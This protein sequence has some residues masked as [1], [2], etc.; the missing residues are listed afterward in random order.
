VE[1]HQRSFGGFQRDLSDLVILLLECGLK[2]VVMESFWL[3]WKSVSAALEQAG[4]PAHVVNARHARKVPGRKTDVSDSEWLA[5]LGRFG[6]VTPSFVPP[7]DLRELRL[8][9]RYRQKLA[10]T[11]AGEKNRLHKLLDDAGIKLGAVVA[12][13]GGV[14]AQAMI[15]GLLA[16]TP[17]E[18]LPDLAKGAMRKKR[19]LLESALDG[20]LSPRHRFVLRHIQSHIHAL[21]TEL[22]ELD[23]YLIDAMAPYAEYW[24]LLQTL[25]GLDQI[26]AALI[27]VEGS[28]RRSRPDRLRLE[29]GTDLSGLSGFG[30]AAL[31]ASW[32]ALPG[33]H[34]SAGKCKSGRTRKG[35]AALRNLLCEA[36]NAA[37]RTNKSVA[38]QAPEP[39]R[40]QGPQEGH[41]RHGPSDDPHDL[42]SLHPPRT[43]SRPWD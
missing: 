1:K 16:G 9:S 28:G 38:G 20:E 30:D 22:A 37:K 15:E 11:L 41:H 43:V 19:D 33:N 34:E 5:Q 36:A 39:G 35:N 10:Q 2:L 4:I 17:V 27:L 24:R 23:R 8:V 18:Q 13:I 21:D 29:I 31:F 3:Y 42:H 6:L 25:P 7:Q 26:A 40:P 32:A 12:D 14:S